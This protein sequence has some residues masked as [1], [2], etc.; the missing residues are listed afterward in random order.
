[1]AA[2]ERREGVDYVLG[3]AKNPRLAEAIRTEMAEAAR[4]AQAKGTAVRRFAEFRHATRTSWSRERRVVAKA[5]ALPPAVPGGSFKRTARFV[6]TSLP[7]G[8]HPARASTVRG[9]RRRTG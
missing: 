9:A 6:V 2:C 1:M 4:E 7:A 3:L 5:E 8:T